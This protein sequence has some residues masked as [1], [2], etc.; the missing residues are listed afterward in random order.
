MG[1]P[2]QYN[3]V[4]G[5]IQERAGHGHLRVGEHR[6]PARLLGLKPASHARAIGWPSNGGDVVHKVAEP[7]PQRKHAQALALA[8]PVPQGVELRAQRLAPGE[9]MATSFFGSLRNAWRRQVPTRTPGKSVRRLLVVLSKPS[10]RTPLTRYD[11]SWS[12]PR[13]ETPD[14]TR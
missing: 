7:L 14:R 13:V 8:R 10:V 11:G 2:K 3:G 4:V 12:M 5:L 6:I 9:A 1:Y